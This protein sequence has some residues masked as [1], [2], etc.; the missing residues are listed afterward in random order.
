MADETTATPAAGLAPPPVRRRTAW[1]FALVAGAVILLGYVLLAA[2]GPWI[3]P[4][5][6]N[7]QDLLSS[8]APPS[9]DHLF[10]TDSLGRD[11]WS[12]VI[13]G[14]RFTLFSALASVSLA[15]LFGVSLGIIAG[16]ASGPVGAAFTAAIDLLLTIPSLVLAIVISSVIGSGIGGLVLATTV[17]FIPPMARLVRSRTLEI[18]VEDYITASRALGASALRIMVTHVLPNAAT[19]IMVE[20]S[21]AAGQ[22]VLVATALGFLGLGVPPPLPEWGTMLGEGREYLEAAPHLVLCP[23]AAI[24]LLILGFNLFGDGLRDRLD[25]RSE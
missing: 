10:G 17:T 8:L 5:G 11:V 16:Y 3:A 7:D 24:S 14:A 6:I 2:V 22:A 13:V 25:T 1:N 21:L 19:V 20:A 23:A 4:A 18:K 12:R 9:G 15:T